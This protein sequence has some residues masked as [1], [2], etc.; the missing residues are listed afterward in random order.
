MFKTKN[1]GN[2]ILIG[3][4]SILAFVIVGVFAW[5]SIFS[6][7][8]MPAEVGIKVNT[9]GAQKGVDEV[10]VLTTGRNW[11]N[12]ITFDVITYPAY[13]QQAEYV[14]LSFQDIDGLVM[15]ADVAISYKFQGENIPTLYK[16]YRKEAGYIL[17]VYFPTWLKNAM[18]TEA[19]RFKVDEIYG[20]K[21]EDFRKLVLKSLQDSLSQKGIFIENIYFTN[22]IKIPQSVVQRIDSKIKATQIAQQ[23]ENELR[24]IE[25]DVAKKIAEEQ[26]KAKSRV[27]E[28]E[29]RATANKILN[30]SLTPEVLEFKQLELQKEAISKWNGQQPTVVGGNDGLILDL[31]Q[32]K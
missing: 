18:V 22:G 10:E 1:Q 2:G 20:T 17:E 7:K 32:L 8:I 15:G 12:P 25:A 6:V 16:E 3:L 24:G 30:N 19:S 5:Y 14:G 26:G 4:F 27:I 23:K 13:I 29:S 11:Y 9:Y 21:K 28:A 31:G